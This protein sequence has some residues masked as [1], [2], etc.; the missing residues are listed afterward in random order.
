M[1]LP[2][3]VARLVRRD[4]SLIPLRLEFYDPPQVLF[5]AV[6]RTDDHGHLCAAFG[7][8]PA[9]CWFDVP[10]SFRAYGAQRSGYGRTDT[11][12]EISGFVFRGP[13]GSGPPIAKIAVATESDKFRD[14]D[15]SRAD[16]ERLGDTR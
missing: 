6:K 5:R 13:K 8:D 2:D 10:E 11:R 15:L 7:L 9:T 16:F 14:R 3:H 1:S 12:R 4:P